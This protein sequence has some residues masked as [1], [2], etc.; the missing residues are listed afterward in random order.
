MI[1]LKTSENWAVAVRPGLS[2]NVGE[3]E[4]PRLMHKQFLL[5]GRG[6]DLRWPGGRTQGELLHLKDHAVRARRTG[7]PTESREFTGKR[8]SAGNFRNHRPSQN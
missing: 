4:H 8:V 7:I 3:G 1:F 2:L 6:L 5:P